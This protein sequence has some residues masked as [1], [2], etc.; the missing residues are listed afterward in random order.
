MQIQVVAGTAKSLQDRTSQ[1]LNELGNDHRK[2]VQA[3]AYGANG[4]VDI[5]EVR[6]TDGQREILVLNCSRL[7]IQAV[8]EWRSCTEDTNEF[9]DLVLHLLRLPDNNL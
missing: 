6:A 3:E 5:L 2:T 4:L 1:L 7:Q 8:L 9:E